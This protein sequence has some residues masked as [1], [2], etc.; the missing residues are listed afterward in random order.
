MVIRKTGQRSKVKGQR[1]GFSF[2]LSPFTFHLILFLFLSSVAFSAS[3]QLETELARLKVHK[4]PYSFVVIGD[5]RVGD[6]IYKKLIG[7][8]LKYGPDLFVN[9]G[10]Q[11]ARTNEPGSW[12]H[13]FKL[14]EPIKVPYFQAVGNHSLDNEK[15][16]RVWREVMDLPGN[17]LYYSWT[18]GRSLFVVLDTQEVGRTYRIEGAQLEWL[19]RTLDPKRYDHQFV[20]L[21][22]PLYLNKDA[23]HYG[24]SLDRHP[25]LRDALQRVFEEKRVT[26]VFMGHEHKYEKR[27]VNGV[28]HVISGGGGQRLYGDTF[29]HFVLV[30]VDGPRIKVMIVDKEGVLRDEFAVHPAP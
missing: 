29:C 22:V 19:K 8:A 10:D 27:N 12:E 4:G 7:L 13:F 11:I 3:K 1:D 2:H 23:M 6:N 25:E 15:G 16:E 24:E 26:M 5:N 14:S 17:E 30:K 21:H 20:F 28:L 18:V 9:T